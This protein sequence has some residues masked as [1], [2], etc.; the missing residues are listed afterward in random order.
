M[1]A[2]LLTVVVCAA[3]AIAGCGGDDDSAAEPTTQAGPLP[4]ETSAD[5]TNRGKPVVT[6]PKGPAPQELEVNDLIEGTG[7][8]VKP[9]DRLTLN[10]VGVGYNSGEEF[11]STWSQGG[12]Y[13]NFTVG[14]GEV[15]PGWEQGVEGMK[16]GGRREIII[17]SK[18]AY[19]E[20]GRPPAIGPNEPL[21][22]VIDLLAIAIN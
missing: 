6:V 14:A 1:K 2:S 16:S 21:I 5:P 11:D 17:P 10:Y 9:G 19:G 22:F 18:L 13:F 7:Q 3:L 4:T 15:I 8:E 20:A 12:V